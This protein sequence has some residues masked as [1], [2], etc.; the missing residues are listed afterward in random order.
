MINKF[1]NKFSVPYNQGFRETLD[2]YS[3]YIYDFFFSDDVY[4]SARTKNTNIR[5]LKEDIEY[6]RSLGVKSNYL[7]NSAYYESNLYVPSNLLSLAE[8]INEL[9]VDILTINNMF[10]LQSRDFMN[11]LDPKIIIKNSV[12]NKIDSVEKAA[13]LIKKFGVKDLI[14]DRSINRDSALLREVLNYCRDNGVTS[15]IMVNEGCMPNCMYKQFCDLGTSIFN[16]DADITS[17]RKTDT[18]GCVLDYKT[19][20]D[21][22]LKSPIITRPNLLKIIDKVDVVKIAGRNISKKFISSILEY[23]LLN[24]R[25]LSLYD[26]ASTSLPVI[27]KQINFYMLEEYDYSKYTENC[28]NLCFSECNQCNK[29]VD[30]II[31]TKI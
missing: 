21:L 7:L 24:N 6:A 31:N 10:L 25:S 9:G 23:Y 5:N 15:T 2:V 16:P 3:E 11:A 30:S 4:P 13:I 12:N 17:G 19:D 14:I 26:F 8:H 20:P 18:Q 27:F 1:K 29:I 28:K 22:V